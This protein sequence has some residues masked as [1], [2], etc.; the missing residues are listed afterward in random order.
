MDGKKLDTIYENI[1]TFLEVIT[2]SKN[3]SQIAIV[4]EAISM[5]RSNNCMEA[6][7][8]NKKIEEQIIQYLR[9]NPNSTRYEIA[10]NMNISS[11]YSVRLIKNLIE[12]NLIVINGTR[13]NTTF[14]TL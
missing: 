5:K 3:P 13:K 11:A 9:E 6:K 1:G 4:N 7:E 10:M 12:R 8:I 2:D 14:S